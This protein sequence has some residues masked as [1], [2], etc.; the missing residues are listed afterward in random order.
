MNTARFPFSVITGKSIRRLIVEDLSGCIDAVRDAYLAHD[1]GR[2]V[3]PHSVFLRSDDHPNARIIALP[4]HLSN[5]WNISGLKWIASYPDNVSKG[6]PRA[7]AVLLLNSSEH[8]YPFACL[9]G[10]IISAART[11]ASAVLAASCLCDGDRRVRTLGIVGTGLIADYI[12]L[13]LVG[14]GWEFER[15]SLFDLD[16]RR[17][18]KFAAKIRKPE[19]HQVSVVPEISDLLRNSDL[20]VFAT[21]ASRPHVHDR[22]LIAHKPVILHVS[23]RD[24]HPELLLDTCN[25]VDDA[26]HVLQADTSLHLAEQLTGRRDFIAGTL[27]QVI[28]GRCSVDHSRPIVFSPFGLGVLDLA[29]GKLVYDR[30]VRSGQHQIIDEFFYDPEA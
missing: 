21:V 5:P 28:T 19:G 25:I 17:A 22:E 23:L 9:E 13:F 6:F 26:D 30:A 20:V 24:L 27:A 8:G 10:S 11:A 29:I 18:E 7:S 12:Y 3:N 15:V 16:Q 14:T 2:S 4:S 1:A